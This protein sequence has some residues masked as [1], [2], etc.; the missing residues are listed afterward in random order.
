MIYARSNDLPARDA[1]EARCVNP[2]PAQFDDASNFVLFR[3]TGRWCKVGGAW[4]C[5]VR[6]E[7]AIV[8]G[9]LFETD[10]KEKSKGDDYKDL[11]GK[12]IGEPT[13]KLASVFL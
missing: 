13:P 9:E 8:A 4:D 1:P 6:K 7:K 5:L 11:A 3:C 10:R 12:G 2:G